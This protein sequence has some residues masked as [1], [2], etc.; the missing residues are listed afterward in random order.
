MLRRDT[1]TKVIYSTKDIVD[2]VAIA[3]LRIGFLWQRKTSG[4][5]IDAVSVQFLAVF[6]LLPVI[7]ILALEKILDATAIGTLIGAIAGF[8]LGS[9]K[10]SDLPPGITLLR[11]RNQVAVALT[12]FKKGNFHA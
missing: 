1:E 2:I 11:N 6:F 3:M 8:L 12:F 5:S 10:P 7:L 4:K 9:G